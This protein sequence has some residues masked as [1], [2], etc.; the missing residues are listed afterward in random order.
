MNLPTAEATNL[1]IKVNEA[2]S[3]G[4]LS[5]PATIKRF[6]ADPDWLQSHHNAVSLTEIYNHY[7][8]ALSRQNPKNRHLRANDGCSE[9]FLENQKSVYL[10]SFQGLMDGDRLDCPDKGV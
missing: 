9:P 5:T 6:Y 3:K 2:A 1:L 8:E 7:N 10:F 4:R